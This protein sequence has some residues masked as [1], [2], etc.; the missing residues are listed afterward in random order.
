V[1]LLATAPPAWCRYLA[2]F[3]DL[4]P[5]SAGIAVLE[6]AEKGDFTR[7]RVLGPDIARRGKLV[8]D[9]LADLEHD[10][11]LGLAARGERLLEMTWITAVER[12]IAP[13]ARPVD[14]TAVF[15]TW[16]PWQRAAASLLD[17]AEEI[18]IPVCP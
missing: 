16:D 10:R 18:H 9:A 17:L 1:P 14:A 7:W 13:G 15:D 3:L 11:A 8:R 5:D 12:S 4:T 2:T 6:S